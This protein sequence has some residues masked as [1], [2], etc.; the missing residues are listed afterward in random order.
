MTRALSRPDREIGCRPEANSSWLSSPSPS[1]TIPAN[2][3]HPVGHMARTGQRPKISKY[4]K[5]F[6]KDVANGMCLVCISRADLRVAHL[7]NQETTRATLKG[8]EQPIF[9]RTYPWMYANAFNNI[10]N[11]AY[12]CKSCEDRCDHDEAYRRQVMQAWCRAMRHA[13]R[14]GLLLRYF[15]NGH[16]KLFDS[17]FAQQLHGPDAKLSGLSQ[18]DFGVCMSFLQEAAVSGDVPREFV[19]LPIGGT[20]DD[21]AR[22]LHHHVKLLGGRVSWCSGD[23]DECIR[24]HASWSPAQPIQEGATGG[25]AGPRA[26]SDRPATY[27]RPTQKQES[28]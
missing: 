9:G 16:A 8:W 11:I 15:Y 7:D 28:R 18:E 1:A 23:H 21:R 13:A 22:R 24:C 10:G 2:D 4:I 5:K 12:L 19:V 26:R 27:L 3:V 20:P 6:A 25:D 17:P 14:S